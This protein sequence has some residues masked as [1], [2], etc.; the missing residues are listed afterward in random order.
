MLSMMH[1]LDQGEQEGGPAVHLLGPLTAPLKIKMIYDSA[2]DDIRKKP[3]GSK[4]ELQANCYKEGKDCCT[5]MEKLDSSAI[6]FLDCE[7]S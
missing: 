5:L 4:H 1:L 7:P 3:T 2:K 6:S